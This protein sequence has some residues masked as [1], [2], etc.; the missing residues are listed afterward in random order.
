[1]GTLKPQ[2]LA[3]PAETRP[4]IRGKFPGIDTVRGHIEKTG[5]NLSE[6][7]RLCGV[8]RITVYR[9]CTQIPELNAAMHQS[10]ESFVDEMEELL[11][12]Q[13]RNGNIAAIIFGLKTQGK[14]RGYVEREKLDVKIDVTKEREKVAATDA[15]YLTDVVKEMARL[16]E[17]SGV[18]LEDEDAS[19]IEGEY[20]D[21][22]AGQE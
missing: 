8:A 12:D 19:I 15:A 1:M 14:A 20:E 21:E 11:I 18:D 6:V 22:S 13:A 5:G 16:A 9:W 17:R 7:A 4:F 3:T 10:R 2:E